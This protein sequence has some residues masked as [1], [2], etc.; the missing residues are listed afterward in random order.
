[1]ISANTNPLNKNVFNET[2]AFQPHYC[3][4]SFLYCKDFIPF[5]VLL[6]VIFKKN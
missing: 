5:R 2:F 6:N 3:N 1:M 4:T